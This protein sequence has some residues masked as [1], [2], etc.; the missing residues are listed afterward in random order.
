MV[1]LSFFLFVG[2][3]V[4]AGVAVGY[5]A[6]R[7]LRSGRL[8]SYLFCGFVLAW[9]AAEITDFFQEPVALGIAL[10]SGAALITFWWLRKGRGKWD[11]LKSAMSRFKR[12]LLAKVRETLAPP[13]G[14]PQP[15]PIPARG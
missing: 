14:V 13:A 3:Q 9:V 7:L 6:H 4:A 10:Y 1:S 2:G 8:L 15:V 5:A 11:K 12:Q